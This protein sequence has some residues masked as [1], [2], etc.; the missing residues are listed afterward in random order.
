M[1]PAFVL[2]STG[3]DTALA[4]SLR[5]SGGFLLSRPVE[6]RALDTILAQVTASLANK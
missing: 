6:E 3:Y 5:A 4:D 2:V 1:I